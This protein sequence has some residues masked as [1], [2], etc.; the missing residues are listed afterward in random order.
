MAELG[1]GPHRTGDIAETLGAKLTSIGPVRA[2]LIRK[3]MIYSPAHGDMA[4][5]VPLFDEFMRRAMPTFETEMDFFIADTFTESLAGLTVEEQKAVKTTAFDLQMNP[6][7]N[8]AMQ[9]HRLDRPKDP[10]FWSVRVNRD[11]RIIVHRT[12]VEPAS[13]LRRA[14]RRRLRLGRAAEDRDST[15]HWRRAARRDP[16][17]ASVRSSFRGTSKRSEAGARACAGRSSTT[18]QTTTLLSYGVPREWIDEVRDATEATLFDLID[19]LPKEAAEALLDLAV[20]ETPRPAPTLPPAADP[21][22]HPDAQRRFRVIAEREELE[23]ALEAPWETWAVFLHPAQRELVERDFSGPARD[24]RLRGN[25]QDDRR[26]PPRRPSSP[27][28][29]PTRAFC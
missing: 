13:L 10:N 24:L 11:L 19:H 4:F 5:T 26:P 12:E 6:A 21:F 2:K 9:F 3:G 25:R 14:S 18:S 22:E 7:V 17:D 16:R 28:R 29:T 8:P 27:A 23:R 15:R 1:P 20:G